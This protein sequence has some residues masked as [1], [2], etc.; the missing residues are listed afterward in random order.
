[1]IKVEVEKDTQTIR[2]DSLNERN[3][4]MLRLSNG[5]D[6]ILIFRLPIN[7]LVINSLKYN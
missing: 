1:M 4:R 7:E 3:I 6:E 2:F 5:T